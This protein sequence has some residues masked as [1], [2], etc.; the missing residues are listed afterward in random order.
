MKR[1]ICILFLLDIAVLTGFTGSAQTTGPQPDSLKMKQQNSR[2]INSE[3]DKNVQT[4][5]K[6]NAGN[7]NGVQS[8]KR[9]RNGRPDLTKAR[10][11]RPP[12]IVRP[13]GSGVPRG[14]GK[15]AGVGRRGGR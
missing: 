12:V 14:A 11:A 15:P 5:A 9:V 6:S 7:G 8:I 1:L 2:S 4:I 3:N 13:S 10:G